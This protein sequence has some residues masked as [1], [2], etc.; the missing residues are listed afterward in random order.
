MP[1]TP[2]PDYTKPFI[3]VVVGGT[4]AAFVLLLTRNTLP[5][6]GDNLHSLP[7]GGTYCDGTKRIRYGGPHRSH[8]P[9][10]PAKSWA[11]ITV[12]AILI[13]LHFSCLR[14]H[15]VHRCVLCHTTSG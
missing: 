9:E 1:L 4:L 3:A 14:T 7:Y 15:R 5:H 11:L 2:P 6:T 12:V 8:V 13:A 10:L